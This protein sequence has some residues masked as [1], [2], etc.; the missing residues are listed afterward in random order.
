MR[1][2]SV[3]RHDALKPVDRFGT[4]ESKSDHQTPQH[5]KIQIDG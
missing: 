2:E 1:V 5:V 3:G 4:S